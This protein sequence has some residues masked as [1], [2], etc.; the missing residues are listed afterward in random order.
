MEQRK[1]LKRSKRKIYGARRK[2]KRSGG[3]TSR[4]MKKEQGTFI[5]KIERSRKQDGK[6]VRGA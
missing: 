4:K 6:I 1:I 3:H 5:Y 2:L